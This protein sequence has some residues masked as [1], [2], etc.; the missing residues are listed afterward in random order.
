MA[1]ATGIYPTQLPS[2]TSTIGIQRGNGEEKRILWMVEDDDDDDDDG[3][4]D[5][6]Y[7]IRHHITSH[8][9]ILTTS[10]FDD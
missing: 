9:H 5:V 1:A 2:S 6:P 10:F 3:D 4:D 8:R 7:R